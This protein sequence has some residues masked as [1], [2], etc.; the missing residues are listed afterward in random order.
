MNQPIS[1]PAFQHEW[2]QQCY[3]NSNIAYSKIEMYGLNLSALIKYTLDM[4]G[5]I[6]QLVAIQPLSNPIG[7]VNLMSVADI[8]ALRPGEMSIGVEEF[9]LSSY[10][11][12]LTANV[13]VEELNSCTFVNLWGLEP[14]GIAFNTAVRVANEITEELLR[15]MINSSYFNTTVPMSMDPDELLLLMNIQAHD[16][17]RTTRRGT[18]NVVVVGL[19]AFDVICKGNIRLT[20]P[21]PLKDNYSLRSTLQCAGILAGTMKVF[22]SA[23]I[24]KNAILLAYRGRCDQ[25]PRFDIDA[26]LVYCPYQLIVSNT[27]VLDTHGFQKVAPLTTRYGLQHNKPGY[28]SVIKLV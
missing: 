16:I 7:F 24:P 18:A 22:V 13:K 4:L 10:S 3:D 20:E 15:V 5:N 26:G 23:L 1:T 19:D 28:F 25:E 2:Q 9:P 14:D 12:H 27:I 8:T 17:G 11:Q 21:P 6:N